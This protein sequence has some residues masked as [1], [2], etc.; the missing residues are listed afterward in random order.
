M[1]DTLEMLLEAQPHGFTL[2]QAFY[3][4]DDIYRAD[5]EKVLSDQWHFVDHVS[6]LPNPGDY[7]THQFGDESIIVVRDK[8]GELHAHF[9]VCRHRGSLICLEPR[10]NSKR[11]VCPYHAWAYELDGRL[12]NA[13]QMAEGFDAA[14]YGLHPC[15][16][17]VIEGLIFINLNP[18][19]GADIGLIEDNVLPFLRPHDLLHTKIVHEELYPTYANWKLAVENFREC[20]H[21]AP[22][23]PEYTQVNAY[24][25]AR[26]RGFGTYNKTVDQWAERVKPSGRKTGFERFSYPRQPHNAWRMPIRE[27]FVTLTEDGQPAGPLLGEFEEYDGAETGVFFG[28]LS[29]LYVTNDHATTFRFTPRSAQFTEVVVT[30]L[31]REDAVEGVDYDINKLKW[32]WDE[33]TIQ[34]TRIINDNQKGVNSSRYTPGPYSEGEA[35]SARFTAWYLTRLG[36]KERPDNIARVHA[37]F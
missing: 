13:R 20:Y 11:L 30:W 33:T 22:A 5:L 7:I 19:D 34:D 17:K 18:D 9:N 16:V 3:N 37:L 29:Y 10:G 23:H 28:P 36:G 8:H 12:S 24:V 25:N 14:Q 6:R 35:G 26:E 21:C 15:G 1:S 32:M 27:G 4:R 2:Q 31:V